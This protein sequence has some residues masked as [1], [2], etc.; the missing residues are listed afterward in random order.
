MRSVN[1]LLEKFHQS[2]FLYLLTSPGKFISVGVYMIPFALIIAPL[3]VVAAS[4]YL[5][6]N[7][8]S[9]TGDASTCMAAATG[10]AGLTSKSWKWFSAVRLVFVIHLWGV[11]TSLAPYFMYD[12]HIRNPT[13]K[14]LIWISLSALS[15]LILYFTACASHSVS[16]HT[17][18]RDWAL[19]KSVSISMAFIGLCIMSIINFA[20]AEIGALLLVPLCLMVRPVKL[21]LSARSLRNISRQICNAVFAFLSFPPVTFLVFK[22]VFEGFDGS[23]TVGNF[24]NSLESLRAWNSA[25]YLYIGMVHLPCWVLC[26]HIMFH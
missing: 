9:S 12:V 6:A 18:R 7:K 3:P 23:T 26:L 20:T 13:V 16:S 22:G 4:L 17:G 5:D 15:L 24:W 2:F 11:L 10:D 14:F 21:D 25:T 19:L 8:V 1:N